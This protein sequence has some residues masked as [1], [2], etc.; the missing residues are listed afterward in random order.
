MLLARG[1]DEEER[2]RWEHTR[3]MTWQLS[4]P[5]YK[6]GQAPRTA[7]AFWTFPWEKTDEEEMVERAKASA[8]VAPETAAALNAIF[9]K[10]NKRTNEQ[11]G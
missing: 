9:D 4:N 2:E 5:H 11:A 3:W 1:R 8:G 10:I 7:K 6:K